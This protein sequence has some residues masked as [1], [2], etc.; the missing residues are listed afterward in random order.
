METIK[1]I[2]RFSWPGARQDNFELVLDANDLSIVDEP[3]PDVPTWAR[4]N[5][6]QCGH[7]TLKPE[8]HSNCPLAVQLVKLNNLFANVDSH[9]EVHVEVETKER[10]VTFDT[11]AQRAIG[12]LMGLI[13]PTSGCPHTRYL[14]PMARF[15]L[16][17]STEEE[18]IYRV[19][20]MYF[21]AQYFLHQ[22]GH[23]PDFELSGLRCI[24]DNLHE[25][26]KCCAQ[27]LR[28]ASSNDSTVNAVVIL[29]MFSKAMPYAIED[30]LEELEDLF[31]P[32]IESPPECPPAD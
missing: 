15:H 7:C 2:Y 13:I 14:R 5:F 3:H 16:P 24:Y 8:E 31:K 19:S 22:H 10:T 26:N 27:R 11:T 12:S 17:F 20:S 21:L 18:T 4:L 6:H 9:E 32:Y 23:E 29:D 1:F 30:S 25:I 28:D